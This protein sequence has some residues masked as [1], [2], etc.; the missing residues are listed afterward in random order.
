MSLA[1]VRRGLQVV[2][3]KLCSP[4]FFTS[5]YTMD[6]HLLQARFA[7]TL[8]VPDLDATLAKLEKSLIPLAKSTEELEATRVKIQLLAQPGSIGRT[9]H[10][11]LQDRAKDPTI[12]NWLEELWD[13]AAYLKYRDSV[14]VNVSYFYGFEPHPA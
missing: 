7:S 13:D 10:E 12:V 11:R 3:P 5:P 1:V 6:K 8:P 2:P 4:S 14:V 9:L